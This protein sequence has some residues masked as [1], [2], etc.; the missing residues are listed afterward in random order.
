MEPHQKFFVSSLGIVESFYS[1][2]LVCKDKLMSV[3]FQVLFDLLKA[4]E[5]LIDFDMFWYS[6]CLLC[7]IV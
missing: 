6:K 5:I 3:H 2:I 4:A 1:T 7:L